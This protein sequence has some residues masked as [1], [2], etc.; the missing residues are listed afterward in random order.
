M[1]VPTR[2]FFPAKKKPSFTRSFC[3]KAVGSLANLKQSLMLTARVRELEA[4]VALLT[5][6]SSDTIYRLRYDTM[7]YDYISP[8]VVSL[9]GYTADEIKAMNF[10]SLIIETRLITNGIKIVHSFEELERKRRQGDVSKW[11]ADYLVR[12]KEGQ[13]IWLSDI[14]YPWLNKQG[15]MIGS[16]GCLRDITDRVQAEKSNQEELV[17]FAHMDPLTRLANRREFYNRVE[18]ELKRIQRS[19]N[20][21]SILMID[22]DHFKKINDTYGHAVGDQVLIE[23]ANLIQSCL[24]PTDLAARIG[25]EEFGVFLPDTAGE[26]AYYVAD[27]ICKRIGKQ[28]IKIGALTISCTVSIGVS[29]SCIVDKSSCS[30]LFQV[31]DT[32]LY[33]AKHTGR[34]Q[35]SV[36]EIVQFH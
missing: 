6:Y 17:R 31:A 26:G 28:A 14:S 15:K 34:N 29:S 33:I 5:S 19:R 11:Q 10:R 3:R 24:R 32:R 27:R 22:I 23:V 20:D 8:A 1:T 16:I 35:V 13:E 9:L 7:E 21:L 4:E 25:G 36:D 18:A 2:H 30:Q 12:T